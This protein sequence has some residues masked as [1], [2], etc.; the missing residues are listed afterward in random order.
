MNDVLE[1]LHSVAQQGLGEP[2]PLEQVHRR[3][4]R[5]RLV[6][7][8]PRIGLLA[9]S[10]AVVVALVVANASQGGTQPQ[11]PTGP[12]AHHRTVAVVDTGATPR[13]WVAVDWGDAQISVPAGWNIDAGGGGCQSVDLGTLLRTDCR[14]PTA[15]L[16]LPGVAIGPLPKDATGARARTLTVNGISVT[17]LSSVRSEHRYAVPALGVELDV[18]TTDP[19]RYLDTLT[20]SPRAVVIEKGPSHSHP[21]GWKTLSSGGISLSYPPSDTLVPGSEY[22]SA[23][24]PSNTDLGP[25]ASAVAQWGVPYTGSCVANVTGVQPL[26][27]DAA[28][29]VQ[30]ADHLDIEHA[31][32]RQLLGSRGRC[33]VIHHLSVCPYSGPEMD[34]LVLAVEGGS[35]SHRV[36]VRLGLAGTGRADR[37]ILGSIRPS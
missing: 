14:Y 2:P 18:A 27:G 5:L 34:V 1:A 15:I 28:P 36:Y 7:F 12:V 3:A 23:C 20:Y 31:T 13:G 17:Q 26:F 30:I 35:L 9:A 24:G 10:V 22:V 25:V 8:A 4:R 11:P 33:L 32:S 37:E 29:G 16:S 19:D 6:R 21:A